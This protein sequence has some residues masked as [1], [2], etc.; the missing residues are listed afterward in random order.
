M[1]I[2]EGKL[3]ALSEHTSSKTVNV[4][5]VV[6]KHL[7]PGHRLPVLQVRPADRHQRGACTPGALQTECAVR[8]YSAKFDFS[9]AQKLVVQKDLMISR[10]I[11]KYAEAPM[12]G[13]TPAQAPLKIVDSHCHIA[14]LEHIPRSFVAGAVAN[15]MSVLTAQGVKATSSQLADMYYQKMQDPLCDA[16]VAEMEDAGISKSILLIADFTYAMKDF[17]LT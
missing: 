8:T 6:L 16:L 9:F 2:L 5:H 12:T 7:I 4:G 17:S 1:A 11:C 3:K 13:E 15:M 14:S 10:R